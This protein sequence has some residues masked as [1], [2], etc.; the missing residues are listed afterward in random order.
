MSPATKRATG[1]TG[2]R[3]ATEALLEKAALRLLRERGILGGLNL[4]QVAEEAGVNRGLVYHYFGGGRD[5]LRAALRADMAERMRSM[6]PGRGSA[7]GPRARSYIRSMVA[8]ADWVRV[9]IILLLD[10][11]DRVRLLPLKDQVLPDL[12]DR[13]ARGEITADIDIEAFHVLQVSSGYGYALGRE[14]MAS[15]LGVELDELDRRV[16]DAA[17]AIGA[18]LE[19]E[20]GTDGH[21]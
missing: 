18:L 21:A 8:Q 16:A 3:T 11:D 7:F 17:G 15:E 10:N 6:G 4:R 14:A 9:V 12:R 2:D 20:G 19:T 13:Q 5:L 1:A